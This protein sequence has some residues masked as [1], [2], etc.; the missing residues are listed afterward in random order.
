MDTIGGRMKFLINSYLINQNTFAKTISI[1]KAS[2]G[3]LEKGKTKPS[4]DTL[5]NTSNQFNISLD[6]LIK[7][8]SSL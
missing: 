4:V 8:G 7:G 1:S 2:L 3:D 5:I 6:W